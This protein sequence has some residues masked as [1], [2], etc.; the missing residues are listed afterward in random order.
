MASPL[1]VSQLLD[2]N[3]RYFDV[4]IFDEA[5]QVLPEDAVPAILRGQQVVVAG[6]RYQLPPTTFF[7]GAADE[8]NEQQSITTGFESLLDLMSSFL[9]PWSLLWH[10]RSQDEALIAFSNR[11]IYGDRL[12]TFP[13]PG[14]SACISHVLVESIPGQD[15]QEESAS[16]EVR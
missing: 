8:E 12:I 3:R 1:S 6:D 14:G 9:P 7:A 4:V 16:Q 2:A 10:Y 5:S 15:G 13:G 11:H